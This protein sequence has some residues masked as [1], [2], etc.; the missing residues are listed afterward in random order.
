MN[1]E[2]VKKLNPDN[3]ALYII[4]EGLKQ[5]MSEFSG[6]PIELIDP[7]S[8]IKGKLTYRT[9]AANLNLK[10]SALNNMLNGNSKFS[11]YGIHSVGL[12]VN[13]VIAKSPDLTTW[14]LSEVEKSFNVAINR[15]VT[16]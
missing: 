12:F 15:E 11:N 9:L 16:Q 5:I 14:Y 2:K 10:Y 6:F 7:T 13:T 3:E 8:K 1:I 4:V